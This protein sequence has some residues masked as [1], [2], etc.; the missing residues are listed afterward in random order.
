[1]QL[2]DYSELMRVIDNVEIREQQEKDM[3]LTNL[4]E[5]YKELEKTLINSG[6]FDDWNRL[7]ELCSKANIRLCVS[8]QGSC[9]IGRVINHEEDF[10]Y[11]QEYRDEGIFSK[12]MDSGSHWSD[13]YGFIYTAEKELVWKITHTTN[14]HWFEGFAVEKIEEKYQTRISLLETFLNTY[15]DYRNFQL[16]R[17]HENLETRIKPEDLMFNEENI[18]MKYYDTHLKNYCIPV[19]EYTGKIITEAINFL[20]QNKDYFLLY[21][22]IDDGYEENMWC[23][24]NF[25]E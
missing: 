18:L 10:K 21:L 3:A 19:N 11:C 24:T 20:K 6:I 17:I 8:H 7:K 1:M 22:S 25:L 12:C 16:K 23:I 4:K 2:F 14:T 5:R 13:Y 9:S 15:E